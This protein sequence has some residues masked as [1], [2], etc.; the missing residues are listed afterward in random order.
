[1]ALLFF[2]TVAQWNAV[3]ASTTDMTVK[4][5]LSTVL[6]YLIS[7]QINTLNPYGLNLVEICPC[8]VV[9]L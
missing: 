5:I 4:V 9:G 2:T 7:I 6:R 3:P 8:F 1:M